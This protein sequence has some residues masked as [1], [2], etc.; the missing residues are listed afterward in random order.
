MRIRRNKIILINLIIFVLFILPSFKLDLFS[1][2]YSTLSLNTRGYL[3]VLI[4]ANL[5]GLLLAYETSFISSRRN[6]VLIYLSLLIGTIIPHH[7]PYNLQ[8]NL[9][10]LFAYLGF[11]LLVSMTYIN[12]MNNK[13]VLTFF[14][15]MI[16]LA[17]YIY[18]R[19]G[20]V[21]T[22]S[23]TIVMIAVIVSNCF[24]YYKHQ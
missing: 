22:L 20:M 17:G 9:H 5:I 23:E 7:V 15:L 13:K 6:S 12:I 19:Y 24:V 14:Y 3:Y 4:L 1:E 16:L 2:N 11:V 10:L 18:F 8:G 21:N